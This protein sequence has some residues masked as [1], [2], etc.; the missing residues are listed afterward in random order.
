MATKKKTTKPVE[1][2]KPRGPRQVW[3][4]W[5]VDGLVKRPMADSV[6]FTRKEAKSLADNFDGDDVFVA[7]PYALTERVRQQ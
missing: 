2:K 6:C 1:K 5:R 4:V 3:I 7:D